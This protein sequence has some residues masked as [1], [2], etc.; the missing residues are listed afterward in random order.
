MASKT[1]NPY[2]ALNNIVKNKGLYMDS[3]LN[4]KNNKQNTYYEA[5][6]PYYQELRDNGYSNLADA[7]SNA[8]YTTA[9]EIL[10]RYSPDSGGILEEYN[11]MVNGITSG[12]GNTVSDKTNDIL[13]QYNSIINPSL[14]DTSSAYLSNAKNMMDILKPFLSGSGSEKQLSSVSVDNMNKMFSDILGN[15]ERI[16]AQGNDILSQMKQYG[17]DQSGRYNSLYDYIMN[18]NY[19]DSPEG[20]S[21]MQNYQSLGR[22]AAGDATA[23]AASS[24]SGNIDSYS[25]ANANR[26]K[27]AYTN[28]GNQAVLNQ[29]N[30]NIGNMLSTLQSLGVDMGNLYDKMVNLHQGDQSYNLGL[31]G[32]YTTG[33]KNIASQLE[34]QKQNENDLLIA[35][36]ES[37]L[38]AQS[39]DTAMN[40]TQN[41]NA[42]NALI[43]ALNN[44][45]GEDTN[46]TNLNAN[47]VG[48]AADILNNKYAVDAQERMNTAENELQKYEIDLSDAFSRWSQ[49]HSE[50]ANQKLQDSINNY[51]YKVA[52]LEQQGI[53]TQAEAQKYI[54]ALE[55]EAEKYGYD[56]SIL[57]SD[58]SYAN[59]SDTS[60]PPA[61]YENFSEYFHDAFNDLDGEFGVNE[62][63][64]GLIARYPDQ[65]GL[66]K[67]IR[68]D[69]EARKKESASNT[70]S[71]NTNSYI[72]TSKYINGY[73]A[74]DYT[75]YIDGSPVSTKNIAG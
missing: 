48:N 14:T 70:D 73:N 30:S 55:T 21:I 72:G 45:L 37:L 13:N 52:Q 8:D 33:Q 71:S 16:N 49:N 58:L 9:Q 31:T 43:A 57:A 56:A 23:S 19:Y 66:I 47:L 12:N 2:N 59:S 11:N 1:Y 22:T 7:M 41:T 28:A 54:A 65:E 62:I 75:N 25:A 26:Q 24:N 63:E 36:L 38:G 15:N 5:A 67:A 44:I 10:S 74:N 50:A 4:L 27:L 60:V 29:K 3:A 40:Q 6:K 68:K 17:S 53:I 32:E 18:S 64:A 20:K 34:R 69:Y 42:A 51:E 46:K 61:G 35:G 39:N